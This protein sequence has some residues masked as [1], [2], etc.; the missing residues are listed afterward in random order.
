MRKY[1]SILSI[2]FICS[3]SVHAQ[4]DK[5][6][7]F[8]EEDIILETPTGKIYGSIT[9]PTKPRRRKF[10]LALLI[11]GSGP[12]DRNGNNPMMKNNSL[13]MTAYG[14]S[15]HGIAVLR[16]DKRGIAQ[17]KD[18]GINE[19]DLRI[20]NYINDA[21]AWVDLLKKDK[22]FTEVVIIGHSLG[23]LIGMLAAQQSTTDK[24]I[25]IAG[26]GQS[27]DLLLKEQLEGQPGFIKNEAYSIID[28]LVQGDTV[29]KISPMLYSLFR[30]S[31]QK[32]WMSIFKFNPKDE[33]AKLNIPVLIV[34]GTTDLQVAVKDAE[35]LHKGN[36]KSELSIFDGMNHVLKTAP[37]DRNANLSTY[38]KANLPLHDKFIETLVS[39]IK[40]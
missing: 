26:S 32:Y 18:A 35:L 31:I 25:S 39:F 2:L 8:T 7:L 40:K 28:S 11:A 6:K 1:T 20:E 33:I 38:S 12:T 34:Q 23:S 37:A 22:R 15:E 19:T 21:A 29:T 24:F 4:V 14:L 13:K 30:P 10:K 3:L 17:S 16:Y 36:P 27:F 9:V 5:K